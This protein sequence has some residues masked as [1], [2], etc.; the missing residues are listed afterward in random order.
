ME[1]P[2]ARPGRSDKS[3]AGLK[4]GQPRR[5]SPTKV[6]KRESGFCLRRNHRCAFLRRLSNF[7]G[8]AAWVTSSHVFECAA[9]K[10]TLLDVANMIL[11]SRRCVVSSLSAQMRDFVPKKREPPKN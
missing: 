6:W 4:S 7:T 1:N 10:L 8:C 3:A 5:G 9:E 11:L 2:F